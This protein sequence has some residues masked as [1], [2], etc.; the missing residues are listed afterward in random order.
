MNDTALDPNRPRP[1]CPLGAQ[2]CGNP[3][4]AERCNVLDDAPAAPPLRVRQWDRVAPDAI[5]VRF[6]RKLTDEEIA[7]LPKAMLSAL[8]TK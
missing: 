8:E 4:C 2:P 6:Q 3:R 1:E 5:V 7:A